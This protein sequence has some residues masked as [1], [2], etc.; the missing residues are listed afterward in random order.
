MEQQPYSDQIQILASKWLDGT[1]T[2]VEE[3]AF[4]QWYNQFNDEAELVLDQVFAQDSIALKQRIH[5][6]L[7]KKLDEGVEIQK[8]A[9]PAHRVHFVRRGWLRLA[10][11]AV[12]VGVIAGGAWLLT[13]NRNQPNLPIVNVA[14]QGA[15]IPPG[16]NKAIL[17]LANGQTIVLDSAANGNVAQQG[18][19]QVTKLADGRIAYQPAGTATGEVLYNSLSTPR[20]GQ[21]QLGL[22]D[23]SQVWLNSASSIKYPTA[24]TGKER[25]VEVTGEVYFEIKPQTPKGGQK[26]PFIVKVNTPAGAGTYVEVLGTHFNINAYADE[27]SIS[28][29]L[30]EGSVKVGETTSK[31]STVIKPGQQAQ[32]VGTQPIQVASS[33]DV[34]QVMAWKTGFFEFDNTAL[35]TIMRQVSRWYDVDVLFEGSPSKERFGGRISKNLPLSEI[36]KLL[37]TN[38]IRFKLEGRKLVVGG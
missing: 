21:Y 10:A 25:V 20:G 38:G 13:T 22:P 26:T 18:N 23:G 14:P 16:G 29:T 1:I 2:P 9:P 7:N 17:T 32:L 19:G 30:L 27:A 3:Q 11:A 28:T 24:F 37:E 8:A 35:P 31:Q 12:I 5:A 15:A 34:A 4:A 33:I 36:L 6:E